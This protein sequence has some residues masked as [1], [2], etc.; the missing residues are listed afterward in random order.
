MEEKFGYEPY[1]MDDELD[2][3]GSKKFWNMLDEAYDISNDAKQKKFWAS[4]SLGGGSNQE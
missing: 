4:V 1:E 2:G 3:V